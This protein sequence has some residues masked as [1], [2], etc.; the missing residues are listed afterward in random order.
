MAL[1]GKK[2]AS[3][4][5]FF[6][7]PVTLAIEVRPNINVSDVTLTVSDSSI[8]SPSSTQA[9]GSL[10]VVNGMAEMLEAAIMEFRRAWEGSSTDG[11]GRVRRNKR[12]RS[13]PDDPTSPGRY[14]Y[15]ICNRIRVE[16]WGYGVMFFI[17][18]E[19]TAP[20]PKMTPPSRMRNP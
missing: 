2:E 4:T 6:C 19:N 3:Y 16:F 9:R 17:C 12:F 13:K 10:L 14:S 18:N 11:S 20:A 5:G 15:Y 7:F 1:S 8:R